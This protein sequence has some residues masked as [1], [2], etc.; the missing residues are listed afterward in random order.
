MGFSAEEEKSQIKLVLESDGTEIDEEYFPFLEKNTTLI[1]LKGN[2]KWKSVKGWCKIIHYISKFWHVA[3][4][5]IVLV[6]NF[7]LNIWQMKKVMKR[8]L[9]QQWRKLCLQLQLQRS[10]AREPWLLHEIF[11]LL[12][13]S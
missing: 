2:E 13:M 4:R 12:V 10:L 6:L 3:F 1:L 7:F 8:I 11:W 9:M 5:S